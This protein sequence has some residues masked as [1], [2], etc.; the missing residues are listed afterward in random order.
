LE[1][2][3]ATFQGPFNDV[4]D[5]LLL[6][7]HVG[8]GIVER[9]LWLDHP[10]LGEVPPSL[11]FFR[12]ERWAEAVDLAECR[13][14]G[15][16]VELAGLGEIGFPQLEVVG[17]EQFTGLLPDRPSQDWGIDQCEAVI[18]EEVPDG[19]DDFVPY[20]SD[21]GLAR[22]PEPEVSMLEEVARPM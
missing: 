13:R 16:D 12:A 4:A 21:G 2:F 10:E 20:P 3:L 19:L 18:V 11:G 9:D 8:I 1:L 15:F 5:E 7:L 17:A 22:A 6:K 14:G